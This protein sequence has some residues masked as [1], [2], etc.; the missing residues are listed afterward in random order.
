MACRVSVVIPF[1]GQAG[2]LR[3]ALE[4]LRAQT[5]TD[6]E[7]WVIDDASPEPAAPVVASLGDSRIAVMRQE[8]RRGGSAARNVGI[9]RARASLVAFLDSDDAWEPTKLA[10][11]VAAFEGLGPDFGMVYTAVRLA[12][13]PPPP[14]RELPVGTLFPALLVSNV[15]GTMSSPMVRAELLRRIG[16]F[17]ESLPSCQDWDLYLRLA[18]ETLIFAL[19]LALTIY[20][21]G[22]R[23]ITGNRAATVEGHQRMESKYAAAAR[24]HLSRVQRARR[25]YRFAAIY[26]RNRRV[27]P[28]LAALARAVTAAPIL[29]TLESGD[30]LIRLFSM[31]VWRRLLRVRGRAARHPDTPPAP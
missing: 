26:L 20:T 24:T 7:A 5:L 29:G 16:G 18:P 25:S 1:R 14:V 31:A 6:W 3:R 9:D 13:A 30:V 22:R 2:D 15:I 21:Q 27:R 10:R 12:E 4:S 19:P 8:T 11:Q 23:G 17:D 28:A